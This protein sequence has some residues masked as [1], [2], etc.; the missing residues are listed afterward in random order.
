MLI[1]FI[2]PTGGGKSTISRRVVDNLT[3]RGVDIRLLHTGRPLFDLVALPWFLS[4]SVRHR[5]FCLFAARVLVR[6]ADSALAGLNLFRHFARKMGMQQRLR[7]CHRGQHIV[8]EEGALHAAHN[9]FVHIG[10]RPRLREIGQ[11][12]RYVPKPDLAIYV[13][14]SIDAVVSRTLT[15]GHRRLKRPDQ[16]VYS[17]AQHAHETFEALASLEAI[18]SRLLVV[19]NDRDGAAGLQSVADHVTDRIHETLSVAVR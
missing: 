12:A 19:D 17:F 8:W 10:P 2:G 7:S 15:R 9:L 3:A 13:R 16:D 5:A 14:A 1:E 18:Q 11:F 6:D 4:F